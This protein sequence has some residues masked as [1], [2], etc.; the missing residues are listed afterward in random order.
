MLP[1]SL[2]GRCIFRLQYPSDLRPRQAGYNGNPRFAISTG[3]FGYASNGG[4]YCTLS[5][6]LIEFVNCDASVE[7]QINQWAEHAF[8][9]D[10]R[11]VL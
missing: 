4:S 5:E 8:Q 6:E 1:H 3:L 11:R 9:C 10:N 2:A 7:H